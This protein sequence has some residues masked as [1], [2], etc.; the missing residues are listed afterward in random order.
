MTKCRGRSK[1]LASRASLAIALAGAMLALGFKKSLA[2]D[3][4]KQVGPSGPPRVKLGLAVNKPDA[5]K[6]YT[7][8]APMGS[9]KTYL[10]DMEGKVVR[11][12]KSEAPPA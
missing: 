5:F 4:G 6:G 10:I 2:E 3:P 8:L 7:L 1:H 12:W 9:T 11:T